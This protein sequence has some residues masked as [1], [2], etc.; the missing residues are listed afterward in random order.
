MISRLEKNKKIIKKEENHKKIKVILWIAFF[1]FLIILNIIISNKHLVTDEYRLSFKEIPDNFDSLK[2]IHFNDLNYTN[3]KKDLKRIVK[4]INIRKPD[5]VLF[6]GR[7]S[8]SSNNDDLI[9][10]LS[11]IKARLG[12]YYVGSDNNNVLRRS[13]FKDISKKIEKIYLNKDSIN[14]I[15]IDA[16]DNKFLEL[17][18]DFTIAL[19]A[20]ADDFNSY[21]N[22][23][24][25]LA[26][27]GGEGG[28]I[29]V[30]F[31]DK[32][33]VPRK[34]NTKYIYG[35]YDN[36]YLIASGSGNKYTPFRFFNPRSIDFLRI[37]KKLD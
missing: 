4:E 30:P 24:I 28:I 21:Q 6:T 26:F 5:I 14:L 33:L 36:K 22:I 27:S 12:K 7:I 2:I 23:K 8:L 16:K 9:K 13:N 10:E 15:G 18:K 37:T 17:D 25:N 19:I 34:E 35:L 11:N 3:N 1:I 20:K 29:R 32:G 31:I